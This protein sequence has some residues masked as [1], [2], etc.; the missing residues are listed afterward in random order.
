MN[1]MCD[2]AMVLTEDSSDVHLQPKYYYFGH[3]SKFVSPGSVRVYSKIV[4]DFAYADMDP[5]VQGNLEV[6]MY[7]CEKSTRQLWRINPDN[8]T[9]ELTTPSSDNWNHPGSDA[10]RLGP[11]TT[12]LACILCS[13]EKY[14]WGLFRECEIL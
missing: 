13:K 6:A 10:Y 12:S 3:I 11:P 2:A 4:G 9:I 7:S 8:S 1:N 14:F 5:N